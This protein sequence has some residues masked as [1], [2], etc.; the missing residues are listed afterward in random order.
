[1]NMWRVSM[2]FINTHNAI[3]ADYMYS[4]ITHVQQV[5]DFTNWSGNAG[6]FA[7]LVKY[8][9]SHAVSFLSVL[10]CFSFACNS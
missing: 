3:D 9:L 1:M 10:G 4:I 6:L 8:G 2:S 5:K 7:G